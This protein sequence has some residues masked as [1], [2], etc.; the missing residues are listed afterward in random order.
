M[1]KNL[2][3]ILASAIDETTEV[4]KKNPPI[5]DVEPEDLDADSLPDANATTWFRLKNVVTV[6]ADLKSSTQLSVGKHPASTAAIYRAATGN[7]A[8]IMNGL[9]AD[10]IQIQGDGVFGLYWGDKA[11]ERAVCAGITV[12]TFSEK[13]LQPKLEGR[14]P[15]APQTGFK[16]GIA[17]GR[18]L[19]KNVGTPRNVNQQEPIW[20]GK[21]VNYAAKAAQQADRNQLIVT[22]TVWLAIEN[23]DYLTV[24]CAHGEDDS[25][26]SPATLWSDVEI[27]KLGHDV[28]D[29]AGRLLEACWCDQCG[30]E[31][32]QAV[33]NGETTRDETNEVTES[34]SASESSAQFDLKRANLARLAHERGMKVIRKSRR[35]K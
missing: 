4:L 13:T 1:A 28:D 31:F 9:D 24:S 34:E 10:F 6:F 26:P 33:L 20:A 16:V 2:S 19:V 12:K 18:V 11:Y 5:K 27:E 17:S 23:N 21:P 30:P 35:R 32:M 7:V 15:D 22:G 8:Q 3:S 29:S 14:W 25:A